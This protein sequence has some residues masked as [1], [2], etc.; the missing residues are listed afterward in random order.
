MWYEQSDYLKEATC[1]C[2]KIVSGVLFCKTSPPPSPQSSLKRA[3]A[4]LEKAQSAPAKEVV[5]EVVRVDEARVK[6]L[7]ASLARERETV[8]QL[9]AEKAEWEGQQGAELEALKV[10]HEAELQEMRDRY[11]EQLRSLAVDDEFGEAVSDL[12]EG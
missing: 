10:E 1:T 11:E 9:T 2:S 4:D 3:Q 5:R 12:E 7:E 8:Q 6:E